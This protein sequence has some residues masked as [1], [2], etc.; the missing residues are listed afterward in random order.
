MPPGVPLRRGSDARAAASAVHVK[1]S[2]GGARMHSMKMEA[3][4]RAPVRFACVGGEDTM[5]RHGAKLHVGYACAA[6]KPGV[7]LHS[8]CPHRRTTREPHWAMSLCPR[9]ESH[10]PRPHLHATARHHQRR[11]C[12]QI[13]AGAV[14]HNPR[15]GSVSGSSR[16]ADLSAHTDVHD[17]GG[18][19]CTHLD[20]PRTV[21][22]PA[23][24]TPGSI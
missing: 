16:R 18:S 24:S 17:A 12:M 7:C 8:R 3:A 5:A 19:G 23:R 1:T 6:R 21:S 2:H 10:L 20:I 13:S 14:P 22:D 11:Y 9:D 15:F 4:A